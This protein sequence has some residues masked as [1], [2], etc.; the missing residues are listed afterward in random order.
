MES[1][2]QRLAAAATVAP[3]LTA[4]AH[5]TSVEDADMDAIPGPPGLEAEQLAAAERDADALATALRGIFA[6]TMR[7][8]IVAPCFVCGRGGTGTSA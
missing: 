8:T 6:R 2:R 7:G 4:A 1:L 5:G 3:A